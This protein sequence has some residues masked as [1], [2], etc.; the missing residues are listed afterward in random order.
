MTLIGD[1]AYCPSSQTGMGPTSAIVGAYV[2]AGEIRRHCGRAGDGG[3]DTK[4]DNLKIALKAYDD[5]FWPFI[6]QVQKGVGDADFL[7]KI[8]CTPFTITI[9]RWFL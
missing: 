6:D 5:A 1:A 3:D 7:D 9:L 2:L 4:E 8:R